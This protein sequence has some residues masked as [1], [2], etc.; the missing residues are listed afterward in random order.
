[1]KISKSPIAWLIC[2]LLVL[3]VMSGCANAEQTPTN[4]PTVAPTEAAPTEP[5]PT[6]PDGSRIEGL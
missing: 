6:E 3:G 4:P 1:M 2:L 5:A